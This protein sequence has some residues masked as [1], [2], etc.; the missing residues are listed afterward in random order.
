MIEMFTESGCF[1]RVVPSAHGPEAV[2]AVVVALTFLLLLLEIHLAAHVVMFAKEQFGYDV[3]VDF[4]FDRHRHV[5][6]KRGVTGVASP[7]ATTHSRSR[8]EQK[9]M[10]RYVRNKP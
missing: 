7:S 9:R 10:E 8:V 6:V 1:V 4:V 3:S 2:A 5:Q